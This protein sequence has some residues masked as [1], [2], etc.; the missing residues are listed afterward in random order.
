MGRV[1]IREL[2]LVNRALN[3]MKKVKIGGYKLEEIYIWEPDY[4]EIKF[5]KYKK[6][7]ISSHKEYKNK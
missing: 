6:R 2:E 5:V 3:A 7:E 1:N 4:M